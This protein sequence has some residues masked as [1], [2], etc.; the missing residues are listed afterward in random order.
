M[1]RGSLRLHLALA[2][3]TVAVLGIV[4]TAVAV[5]EGVSRHFEDYLGRNQRVRAEKVAIF[6]TQVYEQ[7]GGSLT[8]VVREA[9]RLVGMAGMQAWLVDPRGQVIWESGP[10][11][12]PRRPWWRVDGGEAPRGSPPGDRVGKGQCVPLVVNGQEVASLY[13]WPDGGPGPHGEEATFMA[14]VRRALWLGGGLA[15]LLAVLVGLG[16]ARGLSRPLTDIK[17][18]ADRLCEG[19]LRQQVPEEGSD[20]VRALAAAFNHLAR[21]LARQEELRR[22]LTADV[23]HE[24]R[25]PLAVLRG[26][27]EAMQD[28][29][30]EASPANLS[31]LHGEIMRLVR[32]VGDLEKLNE[33]EADSLELQVTDVDLG[34]VASRVVTTF[35]PAF[36]QKGITL[37]LHS[38]TGVPA[39][40]GDEDKLSQVIWNLI[41]NALKF[42][43]PG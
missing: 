28:G 14:G 5:G 8:L 17:Q 13:F 37:A 6:L 16:V 41:S 40:K 20:E 24:L 11:H 4:V 19:D 25:T 3:V 33:A 23:A 7:G 36:E 42:T 43:P 39:L 30:L 1:S 27:I 35:R 18:A 9:D 26:H 12:G 15:S 29:I 34:Q 38:G 31:A 10:G 2:F 32:L 21:T 22:N